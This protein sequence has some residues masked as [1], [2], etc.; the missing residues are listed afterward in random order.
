MRF[1]MGLLVSVA[2]VLG[3][4][5]LWKASHAIE[6]SSSHQTSPAEERAM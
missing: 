1:L 5:E 2:L 4:V 6:A 3:G